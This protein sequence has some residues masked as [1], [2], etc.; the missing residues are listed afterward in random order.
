MA[1]CH[2]KREKGTREEGN[3]RGGTGP[4]WGMRRPW[5]NGEP[6]D[7]S[8]KKTVSTRGQN[9][10]TESCREVEDVFQMTFLHT[11]LLS[12]EENNRT[13]ATW[14]PGNLRLASSVQPD[15]SISHGFISGKP[16]GTGIIQATSL[17]A[18]QAFLSTSWTTRT[19][20]SCTVFILVIGH[21][22]N[23]DGNW[24]QEPVLTARIQR[25]FGIRLTD[26]A[27]FKDATRRVV[28]RSEINIT[29]GHTM[30][31]DLN[32]HDQT[33][34][35]DDSGKINLSA[36]LPCLFAN[37]CGSLWF[38]SSVCPTVALP[39]WDARAM[40]EHYT[41]IHG[42]EPLGDMKTPD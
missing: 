7:A 36:T 29:A 19:D 24:L 35:T 8:R 39:G 4:Q 5:R 16:Q 33:N 37:G 20:H 32:L 25:S 11:I 13:Q 2:P 38:S 31:R 6:R 9:L 14:Q 21:H 23:L 30:I 40:P 15:R 1:G 27:C 42:S 3:K 26:S 17:A 10:S 22:H 18:S 28:G 41:C 12:N 34:S